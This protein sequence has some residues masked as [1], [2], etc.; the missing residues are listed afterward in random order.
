[1]IIEIDGPG[2]NGQLNGILGP[3]TLDG[4]LV[5]AFPVWNGADAQLDAA[6]EQPQLETRLRVLREKN[7]DAIVQEGAALGLG[8]LPP[9]EDAESRERVRTSARGCPSHPA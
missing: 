7:V 3:L 4:T 2:S 9:I 1:M 6:L 8:M 5:D